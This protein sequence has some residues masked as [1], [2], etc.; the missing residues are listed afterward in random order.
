MT[1]RVVCVLSG[2]GAK[3]AAQVG[4]LKALAERG[5]PVAH[6]VGTS[7]GAVI[8]A[9][10]ASGL[11]YEAVLS[12]T[13]GITRPD[14]ASLSP[15]MVLGFF[16][17]ALLK[18]EPL[19]ET[20]AELVPVARFADLPIPLTITATDERS[21]ELVL[22]GAGGRDMVPLH[23]ALYASCALPVYYPPARIGDR[24]YVD[25]GLRAVLPLDVAAQFEPDLLFTV[26]VGPSFGEEPAEAPAFI[27][28]I[29]RAHGDALHVMMA[30][31]TERLLARW[32]EDDPRLVLV[33]PPIE[34][35]STFAV[36]KVIGYVEAGY[37]AAVRA[38][39]VPA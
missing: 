35:Q 7:M 2:G 12:R 20:I 38:L 28:P 37:R 21:G 36:D 24:D 19:R 29:V 14:V 30:D 10:F 3:C 31:Q 11:D 33:R 8:A 32:P 22:F 26:D 23:D 27:P 9:M 39:A 4:A 34:G 16:S 25:G 5:L 13:T 6:Y 1:Q 17:K 15:G 18:A